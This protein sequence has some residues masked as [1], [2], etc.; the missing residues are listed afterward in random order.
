MLR[1]NIKTQDTDLH[2]LHCRYAGRI[3]IVPNL[4]K[5]SKELKWTT[6]LNILFFVKLQ[7]KSLV[8][9]LTTRALT[10]IYHK[11]VY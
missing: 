3:I 6:I 4:G 11:G 1:L 7:D 8:W 2:S 10:I 9:E 5:V